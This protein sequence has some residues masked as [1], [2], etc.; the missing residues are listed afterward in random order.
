MVEPLGPVAA[1]IALEECRRQAQKC[2]DESI[3]AQSPGLRA[4][5]LALAEQWV[6]TAERVAAQIKKDQRSS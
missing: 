6:R 2:V 3:K 1:R 4:D 5:W